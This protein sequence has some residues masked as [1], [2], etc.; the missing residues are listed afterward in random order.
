MVFKKNRRNR[1]LSH[2]F[3]DSSTASPSDYQQQVNDLTGAMGPTTLANWKNTMTTTGYPWT[4]GSQPLYYSPSVGKYITSFEANAAPTSIS[5]EGL[6]D[7]NGVIGSWNPSDPNATGTLSFG[8][9]K[10][11]RFGSPKTGGGCGC[12]GSSYG[13]RKIRRYGSRKNRK[14]RKQ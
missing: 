7:S 13:S 6:P 11:S 3:G 12:G 2:R 14:N 4:L 8:L 1:K 9:R 10:R 5:F